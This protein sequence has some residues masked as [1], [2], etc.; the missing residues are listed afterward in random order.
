MVENDNRTSTVLALLALAIIAIAW[1]ALLSLG[2]AR[3][4]QWIL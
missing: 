4:I 1:P 2:A 3:I